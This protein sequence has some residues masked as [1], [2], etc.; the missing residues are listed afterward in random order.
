[1]QRLTDIND[2]C[3]PYSEILAHN[4]FFQ[5]LTH[6][7]DIHIIGHSCAE[8]DYPYFRKI[9]ESVD[10]STI[11]HF[12]PHNEEDRQRNLKLVEMMGIG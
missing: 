9:I 8:V 3:K 4:R 12:N 10:H 11:W 6:I 5:K 7:Q 2:L 1:M